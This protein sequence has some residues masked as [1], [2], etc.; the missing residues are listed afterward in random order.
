[1]TGLTL[2]VHPFIHAYLTKGLPSI[3][4]KWWLRW[5]QWIKVVP[6]GSSQFLAFSVKD[7]SGKEISL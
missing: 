7:Q 4:M 2:A 5:K 3:R 1:M 6:E